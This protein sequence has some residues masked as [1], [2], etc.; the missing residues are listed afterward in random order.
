MKAFKSVTCSTMLILALSLTAFS[1]T[2]TIST[3]QSGT[4][5]TTKTGTIS[6]TATATGSPS[7]TGTISTTRIENRIDLYAFVARFG[8]MDLMLTAFRP[9]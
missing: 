1:K 4:I 6:T 3:T 2:G 5:S 7:R 8:M 9:W